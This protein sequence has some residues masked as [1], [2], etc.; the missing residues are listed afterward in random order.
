MSDGKHAQIKCSIWEDEH[1]TDLT[2]EA[3]RLYFYLTTQRKRSM[4]GLLPYTPQ[5][6]VNS[7]QGLTHDEIEDAIEELESNEFVVIDVTTYELL[8]RTV[9][10]HDPPRGVKSHTAA[11]RAFR[12][13][14]SPR[15]SQIVY[16]L[17]PDESKDHPEAVK[18]L[19]NGAFS[20]QQDAPFQHP[21]AES[22]S[23]LPPTTATSHACG[24]ISDSVHRNP[25]S[26][27]RRYQTG[28]G[29]EIVDL[30]KAIKRV[31]DEAS[32]S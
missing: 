4:V 14:Q 18:P 19:R 31:D 24:D 2:P 11:W 17:M 1:F 32:A 29:P 30:S 6:W 26:T 15:I 5:A 27:P 25:S 22:G 12:E 28:D 16:D 10:K 8:V 7:A 13:I 20:E 9:V 21:K 23:H 3:Q